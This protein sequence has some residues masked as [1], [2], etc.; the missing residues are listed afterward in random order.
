MRYGGFRPP[1]P[2][3]T[4]SGSRARSPHSQV[5]KAHLRS[6]CVRTRSGSDSCRRHIP[7]SLATRRSAPGQTRPLEISPR[8][9]LA[10]AY[11]RP[12]PNRFSE[13]PVLFPIP[14]PRSGSVQRPASWW[15]AG[16]PT[17]RA[18]VGAASFH[19]QS[20]DGGRK[21][22]GSC[23]HHRQPLSSPSSSADSSSLR[24]TIA[25]TRT[26]YEFELLS[27]VPSVRQRSL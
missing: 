27:T 3:R 9:T 23:L 21:A 1:L 16:E 17:V 14:C 24:T 19:S 18:V 12:C 26:D 6:F 2:F 15:R 5:C 7:Q 4:S 8:H 20:T 25:A 22:P 13:S 11:A 10:A